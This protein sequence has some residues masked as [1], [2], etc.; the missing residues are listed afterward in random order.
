MNHYQFEQPIRE[1]H[2]VK[3]TTTKWVNRI[4]I[5]IIIV[6]AILIGLLQ[7]KSPEPADL[8]AQ[9]DSFSSARA[10]EKL[11]M[12]AKEPHPIET[13]E[14]DKVRDYL[15][16]ELEGLG[17][18]PEVQKTFVTNEWRGHKFSGNIENII[19]RI[20][21]TDN[22]KAVMIAGH[23]DSVPTSPGAADDGAAIAA[24]LETVRTLQVS[25]P[26]KN[27]VILLMSD[28][29]EA[30]LLGAK[31]FTDEHPWA[32]DVG[33]VL[34]FEA[35]GNKGESFMFE[36]SEQ[37]GWIVK[38]FLKAAPQPLAYS[39]LYNIYK[40]MPNDTDLT[41]F[42]EGGLAGLNFAFG[43][44]LD[45]YHQPIDTP[46]NLDQASLQHHGEY[47]LSLTQHFGNLDLTQVE[48]EDRVYF[49][50]IGWNVISYPESL[51][52][53]F[54]IL[55]V[56]LFAITVWHGIRRG[57]IHLKGMTGG[58]LITLLNLGIIYG[59]VTLL[60]NGL[61]AIVSEDEY[62]SLLLDPQISLYYLLG[63]LILTV[64]TSFLLIRFL[65]RYIR[66]KNLWMG[67]L[68]L[69]L[70]LCI[71][72]TLY[73]TGGSYLFTW[74]LI[75]SLIG[76]NVSFLNREGSLTWISAV[77]ATVGFILLTPMIRLVNDMMTLDLAGI[78]MTVSGLAFTLI[79]PVFCRRN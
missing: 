21:G 54:M 11:Q 19:T 12:I 10:M 61:K 42:R 34:N 72:T 56:L 41:I 37:N 29:E 7:I 9:P 52:T 38:E 45:A 62:I 1:Q 65:S 23:Y 46:E 66:T 57:H 14:H 26:L 76:M 53:W 8:N 77:F 6:G 13:P 44:G 78:L 5:P 51:A 36:T 4:G 22:S 58:F 60:W 55:G 16:S 27:D 50:V 49:N 32:K 67:S 24:M 74:P 47:M 75:F 30:G 39:L 2:Q 48:Q 28:G 71:V 73:L 35:R 64:T 15:I 18:S 43:S 40:L 31:A 59:V 70:I 69:W 33:L 20:P 3:Y 79:Y 63:L 68:F 25:G 17:L